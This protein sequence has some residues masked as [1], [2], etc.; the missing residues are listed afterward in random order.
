MFG[1]TYYAPTKVVFGK[2]AEQQVGKLVAGFGAKRVLIH[3]GGRSA[4]RSGLIDRV[5][6][7]LDAEGIFHVELGGVV[8]NPHLSKVRE[9]MALAKEN[10]VD[11]ILAVG[12]GSVIVSSGFIME[13]FG[14]E[15]SSS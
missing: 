12:G 11:F 5:M 9:G 8:P 15:M 4:L 2:N 7:A 13:N 3:Y 14:L 1:F 6:A 10:G